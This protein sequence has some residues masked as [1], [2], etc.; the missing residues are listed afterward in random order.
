ML[1]P[2]LFGGLAT[3]AGDALYEYCYLPGLVEAYRRFAITTTRALRPSRRHGHRS[4]PLAAAVMPSAVGLGDRG[5][6]LPRED[7]TVKVPFDLRTGRIDEA[8][9]A[10]WLAW[11]PVRMVP[12]TQPALRSQRA[13]WVDGRSLR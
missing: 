7:G 9:W 12:S 11:D 10:R 4:A 1:R 3:H 13:I 5:V 6:F 2:D 8:V